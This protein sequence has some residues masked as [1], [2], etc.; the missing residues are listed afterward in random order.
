MIARRAE[1]LHLL[2]LS[3]AIV[4]TVFAALLVFRAS[5]S[6]PAAPATRTRT[7]AQVASQA[8]HGSGGDAL[9]WAATPQVSLGE[10]LAAIGTRL[11]LPSTATAGIPVKVVMDETSRANTGRYGVLILYDTGI[12]LFIQPGQKDTKAMQKESSAT[13]EDGRAQPFELRSIQGRS[14]LV[15]SRGV[16]VVG[17]RRYAVSPRLVWNADGMT[18]TMTTSSEKVSLGQ[19]LEAADSIR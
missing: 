1:S 7:T 9:D 16:Q 3:G 14:S 13:F 15:T 8:V 17:R 11:S 4:L 6:P 2:L 18:Y 19:L 10:A 12:K 5:G